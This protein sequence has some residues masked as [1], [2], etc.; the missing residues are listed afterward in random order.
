MFESKHLVFASNTNLSKK[1]R[2]VT[3]HPTKKTNHIQQIMSPPQQKTTHHK[4]PKRKK[5][6]ATPLQKTAPPPNGEPPPKQVIAEKVPED[7][8]HLRTMLSEFVPSHAKGTSSRN[9][10]QKISRLFASDGWATVWRFWR[11]NELKRELFWNPGFLGAEVANGGV[12]W[13]ILG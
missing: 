12:V 6:T 5:K 7:Q 1:N 4:N 3:P 10:L 9:V 2:V 8:V 11:L 13:G